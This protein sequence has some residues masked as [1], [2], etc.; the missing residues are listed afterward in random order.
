M[1]R[2]VPS[3][4]GKIAKRQRAVMAI[5]ARWLKPEV[6][7]PEVKAPTATAGRRRAPAMQLGDGGEAV[8]RRQT[9]EER[10]LR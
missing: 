8:A 4:S 2:S 10:Q 1:A 6:K 5:Q 3:K 7:K 9:K